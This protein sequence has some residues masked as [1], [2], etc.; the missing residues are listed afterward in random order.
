MAMF[1]VPSEYIYERTKILA[2][3]V[4]ASEMAPI[5]PLRI[6]R[7]LVN[8]RANEELAE[9]FEKS[10]HFQSLGDNIHRATTFA[11][12]KSILLD[13][14]KYDIEDEDNVVMPNT[15]SHQN[16]AFRI[17]PVGSA[18]LG[19]W[20]ASSKFECLCIGSISAKTFIALAR[21]RLKKV[22][23]L[24][25]K[26][27]RIVRE[28]YMIDVE[29]DG[30]EFNVQYCPATKIAESWPLLDTAPTSDPLFKIPIHSLKILN[31]YRDV[32]YILQTVPDITGFQIA[33]RFLRLWAKSRGILAP[34]FGY[35]GEPHITV[36]LARMCKLLYHRKTGDPTVPDIVCN[37]YSHYAKLD[38]AVD[39]VHDPSFHGTNTQ[40]RRSIT[41]PLAILTWHTP[42]INVAYNTSKQSLD[43]IIL[44]LQH[45]SLL[46]SERNASWAT[47]IAE[48]EDAPGV[49]RGGAAAFL[50][51]FKRYI[52]MD[53]HTWGPSAAKGSNLLR[54]LEPKK[55]TYLQ[56][57][58]NK[59]FPDLY[60]R[61]WPDR[62]AELGGN[63]DGEQEYLAFYLIGLASSDDDSATEPMEARRAA[64]PSLETLTS[65]L[66]D[67]IEEVRSNNRFYDASTSWVDTSILQRPN[68]NLLKLNDR[69]WPSVAIE[70]EDDSDEEV[71]EKPD[72]ESFPRASS[73]KN[74]HTSKHAHKQNQAPAPGGKLR[75]AADVLNRLRYDSRLDSS[76]YVIGTVDR[77]FGIREVSLDRWKTETTDDDFIPQHRIEYFKRKSDEEIVW[78]KSTKIDNIFGSGVSKV[79]GS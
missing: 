45:A 72:V 16:V 26:I 21:Q 55:P 47:F 64:S 2:P 54:W 19:V 25:V 20:I 63:L 6:E 31:A 29:M 39:T 50:Q 71:E 70:D 14:P 69:E 46:T 68:F 38:W 30:L 15:N 41:E 58:M 37:F 75:P 24:G 10:S 8:P 52:K 33:H 22:A 3:S 27:L 11:Q 4:A 53:V 78:Q 59:R 65:L 42:I 23:N 7:A 77:F 9:F 35:L 18:K 56:V 12:L 60:T 57:D 13:K 44:E 17:E 66:R 62:F 28:A 32:E 67:F 5:N 73:M 48:A 74:R 61:I 40:Y 51:G 1:G 43:T 34:Q 49:A 36:M 79:A 76:D